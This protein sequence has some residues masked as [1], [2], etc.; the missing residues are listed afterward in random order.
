MVTRALAQHIQVLT[1]RLPSVTR[2]LPARMNWCD[3]MRPRS[4]RCGA[5]RETALA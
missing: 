1:L 3:R 2:W 4:F 5:R